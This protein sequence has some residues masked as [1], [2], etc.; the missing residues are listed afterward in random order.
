MTSMDGS[1]RRTYL[2][3][4]LP[5]QPPPMTTTR[6]PFLG[7]TSPPPMIC[8]QPAPKL[9]TA[10]PAAEPRRN[11]RRVISPMAPLLRSFTVSREGAEPP[12]LF[13]PGGDQR[14][15]RHHCQH[16]DQR[17]APAQHGGQEHGQP[18]L[19]QQPRLTEDQSRQ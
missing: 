2:A 3:A 19:A 16:Q 5:P 14:P 6:G 10:S 1:A 15:C 8:A 12:A 11:C 17:A 7:P 13:V 18:Q 4:L 9:P